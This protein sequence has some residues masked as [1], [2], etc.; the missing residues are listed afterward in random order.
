MAQDQ[1]NGLAPS[2]GLCLSYPRNQSAYYR[3]SSVILR[4]Y[5][6]L[7]YVLPGS[8]GILNEP[9]YV[10][11]DTPERVSHKGLTGVT[12][13]CRWEMHPSRETELLRLYSVAG[14]TTRLI[15]VR[16]LKLEVTN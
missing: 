6:A 15:L 3:T 7:S 1:N 9:P 4:G 13:F 14:G 5:L 12:G 16:A 8:S 2:H 11:V 10:F